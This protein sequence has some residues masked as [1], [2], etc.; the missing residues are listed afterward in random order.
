MNADRV[1]LLRSPSHTS[2]LIVVIAALACSYALTVVEA[3]EVNSP[4]SSTSLERVRVALQ[5]R[6]PSPSSSVL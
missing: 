2:V 6:E 1:A 4:S 3:Q 5:Q